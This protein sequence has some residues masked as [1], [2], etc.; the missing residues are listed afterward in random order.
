MR[1]YLL[2]A[3]L[4]L[5]H[6]SLQAA[7]RPYLD[8]VPAL[9]QRLVTAQARSHGLGA[10]DLFFTLRNQTSQELRLRVPPGLHF[11]AGD[12][13]AQ[14]LFTFQERLLVLAPGASGTVRLWGFCMEQH[15][16]APAANSVY[17]LRGLA[18]NGL[19]QLGDSL[20]KYP[21]LAELYG[22]MFVWSLTDHEPLR[23]IRVPPAL[24]RGAT[25]VLR[26]LAAV[27]GQ[28]AV[29]AR[30]ATDNRPSV[31]VFSKRLFINY[32]SPTR[33][34]T[35]LRVYGPDDCE[36]YVVARSWQLTPGV[37]RYRLGLNT[38]LGIDELPEFTVRLLDA[39]GHV[40]QETKV[41]QATAEV[42]IPPVQLPF[43]FAFSLAKPVKN[44]HLRVRLTDGTLVE[45]LRQLPYLPAGNHRYNWTFYH[46][47]A[48]G[49]SFVARLEGED[50]KVFGQQ[51]ISAATTP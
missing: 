22:Q 29:H 21:K 14:D 38:I 9:A 5:T 20:Q 25:N 7:P 30:S 1:P 35:S 43:A 39:Q 33:Q 18:P 17:S 37:M 3:V 27:S 8:V 45:E 11:G 19:Q 32:H 24:L 44:A 16:H 6:R 42:D 10:E 47:R 26:Y 48:A 31:K 41:N 2:F 13:E 36:R 23:D 49:T 4:L 46:L 15:D 28:L 34:V 40:L 50:G 51:L 12:P